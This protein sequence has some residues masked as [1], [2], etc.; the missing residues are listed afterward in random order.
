MILICS[1]TLPNVA[2]PRKVGE[3]LFQ[4]QIRFLTRDNLYKFQILPRNIRCELSRCSTARRDYIIIAYAVVPIDWILRR[5]IVQSVYFRPY[6]SLCT[7]ICKQEPMSHLLYHVPQIQNIVPETL[8]EPSRA[9]LLISERLALIFGF[10][11]PDDPIELHQLLPDLLLQ[12]I[13]PAILGNHNDMAEPAC[14][15][16]QM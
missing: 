8:V 5:R 11:V 13:V 1:K 10:D 12:H 6:L 14:Q 3:P 9:D 7:S 2:S 15:N 4:F 16:R